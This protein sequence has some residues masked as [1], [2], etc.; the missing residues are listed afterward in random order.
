MIKL[1]EFKSKYMVLRKEDKRGN[2]KKQKN[3]KDKEKKKENEIIM[4][5]LIDENKLEKYLIYKCIDCEETFKSKYLLQK[6][7]E[8]HMNHRPY[9][10]IYCKK[11]FKEKCK[12]NN[13]MQ[14]NHVV[15]NLI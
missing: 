10:C 14:Q 15:I 4:Q 7:M 13:H 12:L 2:K 8:S 6:H 1:E 3:T 11:R 9:E 5:Q